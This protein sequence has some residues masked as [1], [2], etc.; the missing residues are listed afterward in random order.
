[1]QARAII[2]AAIEVGDTIPTNND[3]FNRRFKRIEMKVKEQIVTTKLYS[4][5]EQ[6]TNMKLNND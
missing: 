6:N 4:M 1:M 5:K 2:E 3:S